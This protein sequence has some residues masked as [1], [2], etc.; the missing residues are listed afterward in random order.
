[1]AQDGNNFYRTPQ[2]SPAEGKVS[3]SSE[4]RPLM[5]VVVGMALDFG[6]SMLVG[7]IAGIYVGIQAAGAGIAKGDFEQA[8]LEWLQQNELWFLYG[9]GGF[10][11]LLGA[12]V[13]AAISGRYVVRCIAIQMTLL[14]SLGWLN[15]S[16]Q[17]FINNLMMIQAYTAFLLVVGGFVGHIYYKNKR[18]G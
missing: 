17:S 5:A 9:V 10:F 18:A 15:H 3:V 12:I 11:T 7:I 2:A 4:G 8:W 14:L 1:M 6:G 16:A 13:C